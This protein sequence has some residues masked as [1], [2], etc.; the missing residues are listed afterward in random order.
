MKLS[1]NSTST[2][3]TSYS[4]M[5]NDAHLTPPPWSTRY[6]E[7]DF[8]YL[9]SFEINDVEF[10]MRWIPSGSFLMGSPDEEKGRRDNEGP[11]RLVYITGFWMAETPLTQSQ[12]LVLDLENPSK[13]SGKDKGEFPVESVSWNDASK[14]I[15]KSQSRLN[16]LALRLPTETEWEY[17]CRA[18]TTRAFN[19]DEDCSEPEG[20]DPALDPLGWYNKNSNG[21]THRVKTR[22]PN[23]WGLYDMHGNV[24][25]WCLDHFEKYRPSDKNQVLENPLVQSPESGSSRV[26]RGGSWLFQACECRSAFR[27]GH[28]PDSRV[29]LYGFR[30]AAGGHEHML[31]N[32]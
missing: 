3:P 8:G 19:N 13:F 12:W 27:S 23:I 32:R 16:G 10:L 15:S 20:K 1:K 22:Q 17:A 14:W 29:R 31:E 2:L 25:E 18:G 11:Q 24:W 21:S 7:D 6:A 4:G 28:H 9:A 30:L 5:Q 26:L